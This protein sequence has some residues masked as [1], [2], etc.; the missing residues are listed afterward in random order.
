GKQYFIYGDGLQ[1]RSFT[2]IDDC[3][4]PMAEAAFLDQLNGEIINVGPEEEITI[5]E[6]SDIVLEEFFPDPADRKKFAPIHLAERPQEV[7]N[8]FSSNQKA[9][10]LLNYQPKTALKDG[11]KQMIAWARQIGYEKPKYL[12]Q[13]EL[14]SPNMPKT[15]KDKL[16]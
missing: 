16:I 11:L 3:V 9:K 12:D 1:R 4:P 7:K 6:L 5:K 13:L 15:W 10:Q 8:A 2:Y 14:D